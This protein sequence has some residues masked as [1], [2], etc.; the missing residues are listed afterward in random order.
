MCPLATTAIE[1]TSFATTAVKRSC[2]ASPFLILILLAC[3][4][5]S[6]MAQDKGLERAP[7]EQNGN[8]HS[9]AAGSAVI[10]PKLQR[11]LEAGAEMLRVFLVLRDQPHRDALARYEE[12]LKPRLEMLSARVRAASG[13]SEADARQAQED[14]EREWVEVRRRA[15]EEIRQRIEPE[16]D[17][18]E[19][20]IL[21]LGGRDVRRFSAIN[22]LAADLPPA[23][24]R[25]LSVN[26]LIAE[27]SLVETHT[28]QLNVSVPVLGAPSFW[29]Y[30]YTGAGQSVAVFDTG[31]KTNHPAFSG[32][33]ILS[34]VF[35]SRGSTDPC[36]AD[37]A[38]S[39]EDLQ[40]HGTHVA[41]IVASRGESVLWSD[42]LGVA[43]GLS[44]LY[45]IK[46]AH[47]GRW[48]ATTGSCNFLS[49]TASL[50]DVYQA[51][52]W[53]VI[54][55][56][57]VR[58]I[59]Y[60]IGTVVSSFD[61]DSPESRRFDYYA[62]T[63]DLLIAVSA[64]NEGPASYTV[65][66]PGIAYNVI[67]VANADDKD[68][69]S[70]SDDAINSSSSRGPTNN[71]RKK[72][73]IA[74]PGTNIVS[75]AHDWDG[76]ILG[77]NP[78]F[79]PMTGTS[80]AAPHIAGAAAL[81]R[82][83]GL[84]DSLAIKALL[85]N[86]TDSLDWQ[87]D[88]GWGYANLSRAWSQL[89]NV[90]VA[91][92]PNNS[93][94]LYR[95][96]NS[97]LFYATLTWNR[98][99]YPPGGSDP[100]LSDLDLSIYSGYSNMFL[101]GSLST[102]DN[103][104]KA[105]TYTTGELVVKLRHYAYRSCSS[106]E[107]FALA[108]SQPL[109]AASGP[110]LNVTCTGPSTVLPGASFTVSCTARNNGDLK[111]FGVAGPLNWSGGSGG[112]SQTYGDLSPGGQATKSWIVTAPSTPGSYALVAD[113]SSSSF[114]LSFSGSTTFSFV[115]AGG[116]NSA[117][118]ANQV[119]PASGTGGS[120]VFTFTFS[121]PDGWQNLSVVN[122]LVNFW[123]DGRQACYLAYTPASGT[124]YLVDDAGNA[125]GPYQAMSLPGSG[126]VS[127]SQCIVRGNNSSVTAS[128]TT[129]TL[130]LNIEFRS[131]FA[132]TRIVYLAARDTAGGNSNWQRLGVWTVP[133][134]P[135]TSPAVVSM[136]PQRGSGA[137]PVAFTFQFYDG[138]GA[139]DLNVLNILVNDWLD[140]RQACYLAYVRSLNGVYLV[141]DAGDGLLPL[142]PLGGTGSVSNSQ[143]TVLASGSSVSAS[144]SYLTLTLNLAFKSGLAG[145]RVFYVAARDMMEHN[146]GWQAM[147]T[148]TVP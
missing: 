27:I 136:S 96:T 57:L 123:L 2:L 81:L 88:W 47:K 56:P 112:A 131:S 51:L 50:E 8:I 12:P 40:G 144:G 16:Q 103:V 70:R 59:N 147:G 68:T 41:G 5:P 100:C 42:Y 46:I 79:I 60:S 111:A 118:A 7:S 72:P 133:G 117:P 10:D 93:Y 116:G 82:Q 52:D 135:L 29:Q 115:V 11:R 125:G 121:D 142:L 26:P 132:G 4:T 69:S 148:W 102:I 89:G 119:S 139:Q 43:K 114:G 61:D 138:D 62:D 44:T 63:Y 53:L 25:V 84:T 141:N 36:F 109:T 21:N 28:I 74:A 23:A 140:G 30:S 101:D 83:A 104:E 37:N 110:S 20:L 48:D 124:L 22:M 85:L 127:N 66:S 65:T 122:V 49:A 87:S 145:N 18:V 77:S 75:T 54:N 126:L 91:S 6:A 14:L 106:S 3:L 86:T 45:N 143:C 55:A 137:G 58:I 67:S 130:T 105:Y 1:S 73:D 64:G 95:A 78:N 146:S 15:F 34:R 13:R 19:R 113:V 90:Q 39:A 80:M 24:V 120:Q 92:I 71:G 99:V 32:L 107:K 31:V 108:S 97:S 129:L 9:R 38:A 134:L 98:W 94:K 128:G 33:N 76:G 17:A 35:L